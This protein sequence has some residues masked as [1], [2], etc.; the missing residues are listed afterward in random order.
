MT[1]PTPVPGTGMLPNTYHHGRTVKRNRSVNL[2]SREF[3]AWDGEGINLSGVGKPQSYVLFGSS[4]DCI[5]SP[6]GLSTFECL[7]HIIETGRRFPKAIHVGFAFG[8]DSNMILQSLAPATLARLH[9]QGWVRILATTGDRY[10]ITFARGKYFRVTKYSSGSKTTVQIFD[11]FSF[12]AC[13][14]IKA[15]ADMVGP[16]P[17]V[18]RT[19]KA[20]RGQWEIEDFPQIKEYWSVEIQLLKQL[21]MELR[22]RVFN[23]GLRINQWHGPGA[24]ASYVMRQHGIKSHMAQ[25]LPEIRLA[26]RY[27]YAGGRFELFK[28]G[29]VLGPVY[30]VDINSAYPHAIAQLPSLTDGE[31]R[32]VENP[33]TISRFGIYRVELA[34]GGGF[35]RGPGPLFHRDRDHNISFPWFT[36]GWYFSPEAH[37]ARKVGGHISSGWEYIGS[38]VR[39]FTFVE[40]MYLTRQDWKR[41]GI[42]AQLALKLCLNSIYGKLAQRIGW[43]EQTRRIPPF[44]Q[45]EW[46]GWVTSYVRAR[47]F[48]V[49]KGIPFEN[50]IAVETDGIYTTT[51]PATLGIV[52]SGKLGGWEV[53]EYS[54]VLY[55][56]SG[57]AWLCD[58]NENWHDKRR[59]LDPCREGHT[60]NECHCSGTF[61]LNAARDYLQSLHPRPNR[62]SPWT[63]YIGE[64][65]RFLGLGQALASSQPTKLRHCMWET[66]KRELIPGYGGKR[67]HLHKLCDACQVGATAY[68]QAHDLVIQSLSV[69]NPQSYPHSIPWEE[70]HGHARWRDRQQEEET[71]ETGDY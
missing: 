55:L 63:P 19:G 41:R 70:E 58:N 56:Q 43:D 13:S 51:D 57:L 69:L 27:G 22:K 15:Y 59:G 44:H 60:P 30:G 8:Y 65:T 35:T 37:E 61:S 40:D 9:K 3:I 5:S 10:T 2:D 11:I 14:F 34:R 68:D 16:V 49:M 71:Y 47:L 67:V 4:E 32:Y 46:A 52:N 53:S 21:A 38:H 66:N 33:D 24:L 45:L 31:W 18:I 6:D 28:V 1:L 42:S 20:A 39:P 7:D 48:N 25:T 17:D 12:F 36:S 54:E 26:A 29:R 23:A 62:E 50:L 64:T